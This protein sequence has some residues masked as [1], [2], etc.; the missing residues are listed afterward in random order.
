MTDNDIIKA[1]ECCC[2]GDK[3]V[4]HC[5]FHNNNH[6]IDICTSRLS[7]NALDL[8]NRQQAEIERLQNKIDAIT[9]IQVEEI[10]NFA[11]EKLSLLR[12]IH[13]RVST[14]SESIKEFAERL[15]TKVNLDLCEAID[16]SDYLYDLPKQIDNLVKEMTE[17][18]ENG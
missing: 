7:E 16:C 11:Q 15:K 6:D 12:K 4:G 9:L 17:E 8:I 5:P 14:E 10:H 13:K 1:L 18:C 3:C 2:K